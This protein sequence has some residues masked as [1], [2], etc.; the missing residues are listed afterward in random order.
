MF[1][2]RD[3]LHGD[4]H[5]QISDTEPDVSCPSSTV[6][7]QCFYCHKHGHLIAE[8]SAWKRKQQ[9]SGSVPKPPKG[10]GLIKTVIPNNESMALKAPD[11]CFK[12]FI[13]DG[14]VSLTGKAEDQ[15]LVKVLRD[16]GGSQ[17]FVLTGVLPF[18]PSLPVR[19]VQW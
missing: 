3:S 12:P 18:G 9:G 16:T 14:L 4:S 15:R 1:P 2:R 19:Q 8:C 11:D 13:F 17:F 10:V 5:Q 7:R 6:E